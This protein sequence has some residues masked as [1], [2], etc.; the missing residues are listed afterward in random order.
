MDETH[1]LKPKDSSAIVRLQDPTVIEQLLE[2]PPAV[3]AELLAGWF[4]LGNGFMA[5][6]GC[7]I[8]QAAFKAR[9][10]Q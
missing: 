10:F 9:V 3:L 4:A 7:R 6:A 1:I 2:N 5:A 8:A